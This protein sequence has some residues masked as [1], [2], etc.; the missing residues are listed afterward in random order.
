[1]NNYKKLKILVL[2]MG[3]GVAMLTSTSVQAQALNLLD[4]YYEELEQ[5]SIQRDKHT[6]AVGRDLLRTSPAPSAEPVGGYIISQGQ[7][8]SEDNGGFQITTGQFGQNVP[9]GS[10]LFIMVAAGAGYVLKKRKNSMKQ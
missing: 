10:G 6:M 9:L 7:F 3:L 1:M 5:Q 8:G 2:S 4:E